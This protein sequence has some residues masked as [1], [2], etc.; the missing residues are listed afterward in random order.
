[1]AARTRLLQLA[2]AAVNLTIVA[3]VFTSVWP[4]PSG[5][6]KVDLPSANDVE[7]G[8]S[9]GVVHI[10]APYTIDNG[11][12]YDVDDLTITYSVTNGTHS[13]LAGDIITIGSI[14]AGE[15]N[16]SVLDFEFDLLAQY[17]AGIEWMVFHEDMLFFHLEV[18]CLYTMKMIQFDATYQVSVPWDALIQGYGL[19]DDYSYSVG[20]PVSVNVSY[21]LNTSR[22]LRGLPAAD[23]T[24]SYFGDD[25]LMGQTTT[26]IQL[27]DAYTGVIVMDINPALASSYT[28]LF[29]VQFGGFAVSQRET[30]S[31]PP[32]VIP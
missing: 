17:G 3:L 7:W 2:V 19:S 14:P 4:F 15:V 20:P 8:F 6:F 13:E 21:W 28:V 24:V 29:E 27:G 9:D 1:M 5:E 23:V 32:G 18:S 26:T 31:A 11:W 16:S 10:T 22:L 30:V 25:T 12:I